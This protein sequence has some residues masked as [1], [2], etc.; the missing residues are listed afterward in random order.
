MELENVALSWY[1]EQSSSLGYIRTAN[2]GNSPFG[3]EHYLGTSRFAWGFRV[4][5]IVAGVCVFLWSGRGT[6]MKL[7]AK[8]LLRIC[9]KF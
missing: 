6:P 5:K 2:F 4:L 9:N 8:G 7:G 1:K 3:L